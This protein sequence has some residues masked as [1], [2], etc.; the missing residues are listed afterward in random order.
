[1]DPKRICDTSTPVRGIVRQSDVLR[2]GSIESGPPS[3]DAAGSAVLTYS[4]KGTKEGK[5]AVLIALFTFQPLR[6]HPK[7]RPRRSSPRS[8]RESFGSGRVPAEGGLGVG[9]TGC[10]RSQGWA[11]QQAWA[12]G[13]ATPLWWVLLVKSTTLHL[14]HFSYL[15]TTSSSFPS[16]NCKKGEIQ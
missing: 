11:S 2:A 4:L 14:Q 15:K 10:R 12:C 6:L 7:Q 1:M 3:G 5:Q 9:G 8:L 16:S 13:A